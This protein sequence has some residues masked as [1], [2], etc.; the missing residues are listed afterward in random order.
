MSTRTPAP[1]ET[2][3]P[4]AGTQAI[5]RAARLLVLLVDGD[6]ART[7]GEL[8]TATGLPKS[9]TSRLLAALERQGLVQ[10]DL[11]GGSLRPGPVLVR[12]ARRGGGVL[13]LAGLA[14]PVLERL[15]ARCG[16][17]VNLAVPGPGAVEQVAQVDGRFLLGTTNWMGR[18]TPYHASAQGKVLLAF[19]AAALPLQL[20][21]LTE[22]TIVARDRLAAELARVRKL[23]YATT[24]EELEPGLV[25]VAAPVRGAEGSVVAALSISGPTVRLSEDLHAQ[26]GALLVAEADDISARLRY[27]QRK[28]GAA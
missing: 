9:T 27:P 11:D 20:E 6:Q 2:P 7:V 16:E 24:V 3:A 5:D 14:A 4:S 19:G 28:E 10:R 23:G 8:A 22:R 12:Y 13:D 17:T 21:P 1:T 18:R 26:L 15:G 25:A